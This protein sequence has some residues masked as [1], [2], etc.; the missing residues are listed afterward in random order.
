[1]V[2]VVTFV[3]A[4]LLTASQATSDD[5]Y[6]DPNDFYIDF[7]SYDYNN[8]SSKD[9]CPC[10]FYMKITHKAICGYANIKT[11]PDCIPD[12][13][14]IL[15]F[16]GNKLAFRPRLF[17]RFKDLRKLFLAENN[18]N[19]LGNGS[20]IGLS[21]LREL[22][23]SFNNLDHLGHHSFTGLSNLRA[24]DLSENSIREIS[25]KSFKGLSNLTFLDL[26]YN[27]V[28]YIDSHAFSDLTNLM[29][30]NLSNPWAVQ[31]VHFSDQ[32]FEGLSSLK[33]LSLENIDVFNITS[34]PTDLFQPLI[35]LEELNLRKFC[36][37]YHTE[38]DNCPN[39]HEQIGA[40][41]SIQRLYIDAERITQLGTEFRSLV[42]LKEIEFLAVLDI[43][44]KSL[45]N[46]T[47]ENLENS[48]LSKVALK[49]DLA[50]YGDV[51]IDKVMPNTFAVFKGLQFLDFSFASESKCYNQITNLVTG[52]ENTMIKHLRISIT[53]S[54]S[55]TC[56][57]S[58]VDK[59][60]DLRGTELETLDLSLG[61]ITSF[62]DYSF[63]GI[64]DGKFFN[65]LPKSLK[66][67]YL[68][69]NSMS[70]VNLTYLYTLEHL[71]I[72]DMSYQNQWTEI[73]KKRSVRGSKQG[74]SNTETYQMEM[75]DPRALNTTTEWTLGGDEEELYWSQE[76][77]LFWS[78]EECY[79]LP[80]TL[81][82]MD[83]SYS[84][85]FY[86]VSRTFC[87]TNN[88]LKTLNL[89]NLE[90]IDLK[91]LWK[92]LDTLLQLEDLNLNGNGIR[93][94]PSDAFSK[95]TRMKSLSIAD[96][97]LVSANFEMH[98]MTNLEWLDLSNNNIQY[99]SDRFASQ[100]ERIAENQPHL[101][102]ILDENPLI[103][104]CDRMTF[105]KW[106][107]DTKVVFKWLLSC[108]YKNG[109]LISLRKVSEIYAQLQREC[110]NSTESHNSL[111]LP[112][113]SS[114][115]G[116]IILSLFIFIA[117]LIRRIRQ[118]ADKEDRNTEDNMI[119]T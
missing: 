90:F 25:H 86:D 51:M 96:N 103:C 52:L 43:H 6:T 15:N 16:E 79:P 98:A 27:E 94:I 75:E 91:Y 45:S 105:V 109:S 56:N 18:L 63:L 99:V 7:N 9:D 34:F 24:L 33:Y 12:T 62:D 14:L 81:Q 3:T 57:H 83:I 8:K 39:L 107:R 37:S 21:E 87:D 108:T 115:L 82:F 113:V 17:E 77:E 65:K 72:L 64:N 66:Y 11:V 76:G 111:S 46:K 97:N 26:S 4:I 47:F 95:L 88:S 44:V 32:S 42:N 50:T 67:L 74:M 69:H 93:S 38:V 5:N 59:P 60:P 31:S 54:P 100:I 29:V 92:S 114:V 10:S 36:R 22:D 58:V 68:Q 55:L 106:L 40:T 84:S 70:S 2:A 85:L 1:M 102:V 48:P 71:L 73:R 104:D 28:T 118:K 112:I 41:P 23:L 117:A 61:S 89:S 110:E 80:L 30:L 101:I 78:Q 119:L 20:F 116:L 13:A 53:G 19:H 49:T 35:S